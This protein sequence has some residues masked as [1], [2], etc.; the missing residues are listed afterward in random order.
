MDKNT[1]SSSESPFI[2][3]RWY[4]QYFQSLRSYSRENPIFLLFLLLMI[5]I[6]IFAFQSTLTYM[7]EAQTAG[8]VKLTFE[9]NQ[10]VLPGNTNVKVMME[11]HSGNIGFAKVVF[12]FDKNRVKL[13]SEIASSPL[14][15]TIIEKTSMQNANL[16]GIVKIIIAAPPGS[17]LPAGF[18]E[19]ASFTLG[20]ASNVSPQ[21]NINFSTQEIQ[22]VTSDQV[23]L[24][25]IVTNLKIN[26]G[27]SVTAA[28]PSPTTRI[29][30]SAT[31][32][33]NNP[34]PTPFNGSGNSKVMF[35]KPE[36]FLPPDTDLKITLS[37]GTRKTAFARVVFTFDRTKVKLTKEIT[38]SANLKTVVDITKMN[39]ANSTGKAV[40][41]LAA[42]P[43]DPRPSG[44]FELASISFGALRRGLG[45]SKVNFDVSDMQVV[46]EDSNILPVTSLSL[47]INPRNVTPTPGTNTDVCQSL[48]SLACFRQWTKEFT[49]IAETKITDFNKDAKVD[50]NDF[51]SIRRALFR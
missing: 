3:P 23:V 19:F 46:D 27:Q 12:T 37:S 5:P 47:L 16:T 31:P 51:E 22:I 48:A 33:P 18:F 35:S 9:P 30:V 6:T 2:E 25:P 7:S 20:S 28:P 15:S 38:P 17:V 8:S 50:M 14:L 49:G 10:I 44:D 24:A 1:L 34:S 26:S 29:I 11:P 45:E 41:V 13:S 21:S 32:L 39:E 43:G 36:V 4:I 40:I 42:A